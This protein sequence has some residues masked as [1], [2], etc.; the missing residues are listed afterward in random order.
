[1][2]SLNLFPFIFPL[3]HPK[4]SLLKVDS[5]AKFFPDGNFVSANHI[6][7][8]ILLAEN[9]LEWKYG[10]LLDIWATNR[11]IQLTFVCVDYRM[12]KDNRLCQQP[13]RLVKGY[14]LS[15]KQMV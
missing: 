1:M 8:I 15:T 10:P 12:K 7:Q 13:E 14:S 9:F 11:A 4:I 2:A 5:T 6:L 3:S